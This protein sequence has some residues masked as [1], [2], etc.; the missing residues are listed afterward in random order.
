MA[1]ELLNS[2]DIVTTL[3]Q[4]RRKEMPDLM[5]FGNAVLMLAISTPLKSE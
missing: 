2:Q 1:T 3:E 5:E 4:V